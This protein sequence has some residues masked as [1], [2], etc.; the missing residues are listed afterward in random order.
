MC[1]EGGRGREAKTQRH[2]AR[3]RERACLANPDTQR[4]LTVFTEASAWSAMFIILRVELRR[5]FRNTLATRSFMVWALIF[6]GVRMYMLTA[7]PVASCGVFCDP[8]SSLSD[9]RWRRLLMTHL[10]FS[11]P[12][13]FSLLFLPL[14]SRTAVVPLR[15]HRRS[16]LGNGHD[17]KLRPRLPRRARGIFCRSDVRSANCGRRRRRRRQRRIVWR[18]R[19]LGRGRGRR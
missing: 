7:V 3:E 14:P 6:G 13:P 4:P 11:F 2:T 8:V 1:G 17:G 5:A 19:A 12:S 15:R 9:D 10:A 18:F 16:L